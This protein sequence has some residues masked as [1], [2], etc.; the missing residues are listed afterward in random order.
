MNS[1][2]NKTWMH[3]TLAELEA[4]LTAEE[5]KWVEEHPG[6]YRALVLKKFKKEIA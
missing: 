2:V 1:I 3:R 4:N 5:R 6:E